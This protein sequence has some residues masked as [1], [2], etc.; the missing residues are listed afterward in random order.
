VTT[1]RVMVDPAAPDPEVIAEAAARLRSGELVIFPTETVYG[2]GACGLDAEALVEIYRVKERPPEKGLILAV[3][4]PEHVTAVAREVGP[5]AR[6]LMERFFP[7]PLTLVL[8]ARD[9][10]PAIVT[11]G[12]DTVAVRMPDHPVALA[13]VRA[14]G[15]PVA[16]PSANRSGEPPP[17]TAMEA[18]HSLCGRV[19]LA[20]DAGP[21]PLGT[22]S[23][24]LDLT[25]DPPRVLREGA[26]SAAELDVF[27]KTAH[28]G[29]TE[30]RR[31][32]F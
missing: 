13:L 18:V 16:A 3:G 6:M 28:H 12:G 11:A 1:R 26:I 24:I 27:L 19:A 20:L 21:C 2:L 25:V 7:G 14:C 4:A 17:R 10:V 8:P 9:I 5:L 15:A 30:T 22:P 23:T 32:T 31:E 29:D